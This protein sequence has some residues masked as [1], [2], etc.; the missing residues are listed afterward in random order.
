MERRP[1]AQSR[2]P[3]M[4]VTR[5]PQMNVLMLESDCDKRANILDGSPTRMMN[6]A[7]RRADPRFVQYAS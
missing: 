2:N 4:P 1:A 7:S 3:K 5:L 6:G